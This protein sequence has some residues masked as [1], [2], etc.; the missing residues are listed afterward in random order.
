VEKSQEEQWAVKWANLQGPSVPPKIMVRAG[1]SSSKWLKVDVYF[2]LGPGGEFPVSHLP[3]G[4]G[5][6]LTW[7]PFFVAV[8]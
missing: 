1:Y 3:Q 4:G 8:S 5:P 6:V 7:L 2:S